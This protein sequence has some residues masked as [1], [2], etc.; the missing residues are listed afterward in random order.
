VCSS[1]LRKTITGRLGTGVRAVQAKIKERARRKHGTVGAMLLEKYGD[2]EAPWFDPEFKRKFEEAIESGDEDALTEIAQQIWGHTRDNPIITASGNRFSADVAFINWNGYSLTVHGTIYSEDGDES[3]GLGTFKRILYTDDG[4]I[5]VENELLTLGSTDGK[6]GDDSPDTAARGNGFA[7]LFNGHANVWLKGLGADEVTLKTGWDGPYVWPRAGFRQ[8]GSGLSSS[9]LSS[10]AFDLEQEVDKFVGTDDDSFFVDDDSLIRS[11]EMAELVMELINEARERRYDTDAPQN[12]EYMIALEDGTDEQRARILDFFREQRRF[13]SGTMKMDD[14]PD[15]PRIVHRELLAESPDPLLPTRKAAAPV[16]GESANLPTGF[17]QATVD[18]SDLEE[19][20]PPRRPYHPSA[21]P[22]SGAAQD[23]ADKANGD[24]GRF[25]ELLD[26]EGYVVI[27]YE[28]PG[29]D[30]ENVP[31]QVGIVQDL[32]AEVID[33]MNLFMN[34]NSPL[35]EWSKKNLRDADGNLITAEWLQQQRSVGDVHQDVAEFIGDSIAMA[36][37]VNFDR[38][39]LERSMGQADIDF[40]LAGHIDTLSLLRETVPRGDGETGPERYTLGKLAEFFDVELGDGAHT[41]DADAEATN[42]MFRAAARFIQDA[43]VPPGQRDASQDILN[44]ERQESRH[45]AAVEEYDAENQRYRKELAKYEE[46]LAEYRRAVVTGG[47]IDE[48]EAPDAPIAFQVSDTTPVDPDSVIESQDDSVFNDSSQQFAFGFTEDQNRFLQDYLREQ[49]GPDEDWRSPEIK[50]ADDGEVVVINRDPTKGLTE[51]DDASAVETKA[52][53]VHFLALRLEQSGIMEDFGDLFTS[54]FAP[55][56][57]I[58][59]GTGRITLASGQRSMMVSEISQDDPNYRTYLAEAI[60]DE[61]VSSWAIGAWSDSSPHLQESVAEVFGFSDIMQKRPGRDETDKKVT[62]AAMAAIARTMY[63]ETQKMYAAAGATSVPAY[64]GMSLDG[65]SAGEWRS[66]SS[67]EGPNAALMREIVGSIS[68]SPDLDAAF[69]DMSFMEL[70]EL[71]GL[72]EDLEAYEEI[73]DSDEL[74]GIQWTED[75]NMNRHLTLLLGRIRT[76]TVDVEQLSLNPLNSFSMSRSMAQEFEQE[77][78]FEDGTE[79]IGMTI[80]ANV[81]V[82]R[83]FSVPITGPG[84][85]GE[86][87][88]VII[89]GPPMAAR[90]DYTLSREMI[91]SILVDLMLS[92]ARTLRDAGGFETNDPFFEE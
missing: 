47:E 44:R 56:V 90:V 85:Y 91:G 16:P 31:I 69:E 41:A 64:R 43:P 11:E 53:L 76:G 34:P 48:P 2:G 39:V 7:N 36:H 84:S 21:L 42:E 51:D 8:E 74:D 52:R 35:S 25:M 78:F 66:D 3:V 30:V 45:R 1:D 87:E 27:D 14:F 70:P 73:P 71:V 81:P 67:G 68:N 83:V 40:E 12:L 9:V 86:S 22:L 13:P 5:K 63:E 33:R 24:F 46:K 49:V 18:R 79:L 19:P 26:A 59:D 32:N 92:R 80:S 89:G 57:H 62:D 72:I 60:M 50:F 55:A 15:D 82:D 29:F 10:L 58:N 61:V 37:N 20:T 75:P 6:I 17:T 4:P 38:E 23:L 65:E 28:T 54:G 88:L 77:N